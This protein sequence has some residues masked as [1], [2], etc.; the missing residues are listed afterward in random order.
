M[1]KKDPNEELLP[2]HL[3]QGHA[4]K[5]SK[6]ISD[7]EDGGKGV[8]FV[9]STA[10]GFVGGTPSKDSARVAM[11]GRVPV[12]LCGHAYVDWYLVPSGNSDGL[13]R[14]VSP[15]E[16]QREPHLWELCF[17]IVWELLPIDTLGVPSVL[18]FVSAH[19]TFSFKSRATTD[20]AFVSSVSLHPPRVHKSLRPYQ[21]DAVAR[22]GCENRKE[23]SLSSIVI[24]S[25]HANSLSSF[26]SSQLNSRT[27]H[28]H[29]PMSLSCMRAHS[30]IDLYSLSY[31]R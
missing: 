4:N 8:L 7:S 21:L 28:P 24:S 14:C 3:V 26:V 13:A 22:I 6:H 11:V 27:R 1:V 20:S 12:R 17:G 2:G 18:A 19:P 9:V 15:I 25:S 31:M 29:L 30:F 5:I 23:P 10:P 16:L